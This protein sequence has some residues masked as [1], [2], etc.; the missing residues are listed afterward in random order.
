[1]GCRGNCGQGQC[2]CRTPEVCA[3]PESFWKAFSSGVCTGLL[4]AGAVIVGVEVAKILN[5]LLE[6]LR[7]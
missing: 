1:M 7:G 3:Q 2:P 5:N 4:L 6:V